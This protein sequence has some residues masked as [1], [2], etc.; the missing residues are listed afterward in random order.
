[1]SMVIWSYQEI[2]KRCFV[3]WRMCAQKQKIKNKMKQQTKKHSNIYCCSSGFA[4]RFFMPSGLFLFCTVLFSTFRYEN[5][6]QMIYN[7]LSTACI[8][9]PLLLTVLIPSW[10]TVLTQYS[11]RCKCLYGFL[12]EY[13]ASTKITVTWAAF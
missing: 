2:I 8:S 11:T 1:M 3:K 7:F 4:W 5:A 13:E 10:Q 6:K 12:I 9:V